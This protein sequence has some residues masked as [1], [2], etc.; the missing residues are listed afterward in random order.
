LFPPPRDR[1]TRPSVSNLSLGSLYH[2]PSRPAFVL[3]DELLAKNF[4]VLGTTGSGK[5]CAIAL[6]LSA[7]LAGQA[8]AHI[9]VL[10]VK[11]LTWTDENL[12]RQVVYEGL[13]EDK[14]RAEVRRPSATGQRP[15]IL[16]TRVF[17]TR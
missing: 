3:V 14:D 6:I 7:I 2:D 16:S 10:E 13:R 17:P 8:H 1:Y 9:V 12:L 11:Y 4:A 15:R 5:S